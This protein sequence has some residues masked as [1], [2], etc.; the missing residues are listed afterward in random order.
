MDKDMHNLTDELLYFLNNKTY[1]GG[2]FCNFLRACNCV[3]HD[4]LLLPFNI[5]GIQRHSWAVVGII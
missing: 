4:I 5:Y 1:S 2:F 3:T